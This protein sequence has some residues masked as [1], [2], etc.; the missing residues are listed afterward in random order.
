MAVKLAKCGANITI[1]AR[2]MVRLGEI[3]YAYVNQCT[4]SEKQILVVAR[5]KGLGH[6]PR[7]CKVPYEWPE[8]L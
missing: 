4:E 1:L 6:I 2:N 7:S 8:T 3:L 5:G